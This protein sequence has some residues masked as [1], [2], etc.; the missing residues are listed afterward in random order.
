MLLRYCNLCSQLE[1]Q[2]LCRWFPPQYVLDYPAAAEAKVAPKKAASKK[3]PAADLE[4]EEEEEEEPQPAKKASK[5]KAAAKPTK[6][7][8]A[9]VGAAA[10]YACSLWLYCWCL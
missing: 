1:Q 5:A 3:R 7:P 2:P 10:V 4:E 9:K 8:A 6:Q